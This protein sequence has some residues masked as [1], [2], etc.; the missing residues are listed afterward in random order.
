MTV[1]RAIDISG[2]EILLASGD[3]QAMAISHARL[4]ARDGLVR[5]A[6]VLQRALDKLEMIGATRPIWERS[7][8]RPI[9]HYPP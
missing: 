2:Y 5:P 7:D 8:P 6:P 9:A 4:A 1:H 3:A